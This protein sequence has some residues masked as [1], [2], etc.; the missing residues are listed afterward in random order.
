VL[1]QGSAVEGILT[2]AERTTVDL[3][4]LSTHG[5]S[6]IGR[7]VRGGVADRVARAAA[8]PVLL[9]RPEGAVH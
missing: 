1:E 8:V 4:A 3:I 6:C 5:R 2:Y 7:F 9:Y